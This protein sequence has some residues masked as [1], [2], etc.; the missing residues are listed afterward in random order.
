MGLLDSVFS[1]AVNTT[2]VVLAPV[3]VV[4]DLANAVVEPV[5]EAV[6]EIVKDVKSISK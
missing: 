6:D 2:K 4:A 1:L 3:E 5:K